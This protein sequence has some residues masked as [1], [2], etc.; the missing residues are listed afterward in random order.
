MVHSSN[1]SDIQE[2]VKAERLMFNILVIALHT[3]MRHFEY[4]IS[5]HHFWLR[6]GCG[7]DLTLIVFVY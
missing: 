7:R 4:V 5:K 1:L 2:M 6:T 3:C